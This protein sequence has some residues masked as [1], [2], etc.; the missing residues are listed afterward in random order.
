MIAASHE[1]IRKLLD[2]IGASLIAP[3]LFLCLGFGNSRLPYN[4]WDRDFRMKLTLTFSIVLFLFTICVIMIQDRLL[5]VDLWKAR[6]I[7]YSFVYLVF[8]S[9]MVVGLISV[10]HWKL[11]PRLWRKDHCKSDM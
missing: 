9:L 10:I 3:V 4:R 6:P 2:D 1:T 5:L 8:S 11:R 7:F